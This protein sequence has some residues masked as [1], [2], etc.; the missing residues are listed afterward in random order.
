MT[1]ELSRFRRFLYRL[2]SV[3]GDV[4]AVK[5]GKVGRRIV[6]KAYYRSTGK[7]FRKLFK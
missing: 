5:R 3:L 7:L 2:A 4:E 1:S 6:S